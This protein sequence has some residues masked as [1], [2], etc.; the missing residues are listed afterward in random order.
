MLAI[1]GVRD[2]C[3]FLPDGDGG[4]VAR[5]AAFE[6][7]D[8]LSAAEIAAALRERIDP[9][10]L[11]RPLHLVERLPRNAAGKLPRTAL[12]ALLQ[13]TTGQQR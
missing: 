4:T 5:L 9:V 8:S 1:P 6:V 12:Q 13:Q 3:F 10:F 2:G 11:P 7:T